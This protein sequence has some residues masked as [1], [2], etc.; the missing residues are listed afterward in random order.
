LKRG[1][2]DDLVIAPYATVLAALID[3]QSAAANLRQLTSAGAFGRY[4]FYE[5]IDYTPRD[6]GHDGAT[7]TEHRERG[8]VVR[9]YFAHHQAMS[10]VALAN[11]LDGGRF[12][13]RFHADPRVQA[14]E[15]LLQ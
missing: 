4:G 13:A 15:L 14:T 11:V 1:L 10:L 6:D 12:V 5:A 3:A 2:G 7:A 9:A 8:T